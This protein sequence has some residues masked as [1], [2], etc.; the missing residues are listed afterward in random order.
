MSRPKKKF[1]SFVVVE[2][3][4]SDFSRLQTVIRK[5]TYFV[6][7]TTSLVVNDCGEIVSNAAV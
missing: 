2:F 6:F 7:A 3:I 1:A 5:I 4:G